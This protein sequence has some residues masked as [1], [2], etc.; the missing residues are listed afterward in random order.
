MYLY[1]LAHAN[2]RACGEMSESIRSIANKGAL[3]VAHGCTDK[4]ELDRCVNFIKFIKCEFCDGDGFCDCL[5]ST[6]KVR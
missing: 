4:N 6:I 3:K 2:R 5:Y 1:A